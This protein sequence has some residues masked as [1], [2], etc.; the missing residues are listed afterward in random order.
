MVYGD[1]R[2]N[3]AWKMHLQVLRLRKTF[4]FIGGRPPRAATLSRLF[5][6]RKIRGG[7]LF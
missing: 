7:S 5:R 1:F 2:E 3:S 4:G 6:T